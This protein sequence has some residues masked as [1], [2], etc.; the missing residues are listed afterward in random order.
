[1]KL[2]PERWTRIQPSAYEYLPFGAGPRL[3]IGMGFASQVLRI[4]LPMLLNRFKFELMEGSKVSRKVQGITMGPKFGLPMRV[5][6]PDARVRKA[7]TVR[8]DIHELVALN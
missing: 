7:S 8:G 3:C 2:K 4:V 6:A 1:M 5:L